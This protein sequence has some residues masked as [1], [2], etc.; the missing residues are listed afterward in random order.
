MVSLS[1]AGGATSGAE[2]SSLSTASGEMHASRFR[3]GAFSGPS[4]FSWRFARKVRPSFR[5]RSNIAVAM[6][7]TS[8]GTGFTIKR[9]IGPSDGLCADRSPMLILLCTLTHDSLLYWALSKNSMTTYDFCLNV[10]KR[11]FLFF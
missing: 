7:R 1:S 8:F 6:L 2:G 4:K 9:D 10:F 11:K 5:A 3:V